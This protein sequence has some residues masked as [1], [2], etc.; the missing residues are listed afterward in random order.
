[1]RFRQAL[2]RSGG[3]RTRVASCCEARWRS[4]SASPASELVV[5]NGSEEMIAAAARSFLT[6]GAVALTVAPSF[7]LHEIEPLAMGARIVEV[8]MTGDFGFDVP[9]LVEGAGRARPSLVF[10]RPVEPRRCGARCRATRQD[11]AGVV[12]FDLVRARR[13]LSGVRASGKCRTGS[14]SA[15]RACTARG[16]SNVLE[17]LT[18]SRA[19]A[20][21]TRSAPDSRIAKMLMAAKTPFNVEL[22]RA[23]RRRGRVAG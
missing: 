21:A 5:G 6:A 2:S 23:D 17:K 10:C 18:D 15:G 9:G 22:R 14:P 12:P 13:G 1:M 4:A 3:T 19:C 16:A 7:G 11:R 8:P 20:S